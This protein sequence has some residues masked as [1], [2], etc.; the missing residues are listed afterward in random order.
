[1]IDADCHWG[2]SGGAAVS[3]RI[4]IWQNLEAADAQWQTLSAG[5][6]TPLDVGDEGFIADEPRA[7]V[8]RTHAG[9]AVATIRLTSATG[10][11]DIAPLRQAAP[12]IANDI[13]DDLLP[14]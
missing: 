10:S 8:V 13:L 14:A 6:S 4:S 11:T 7:V 9:N 1:V 12:D 2:S 5:Q 3:A